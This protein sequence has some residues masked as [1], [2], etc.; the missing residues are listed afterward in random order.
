M[1][2][3][4]LDT[5]TQQRYL[6]WLLATKMTAPDPGTET[7]SGDMSYLELVPLGGLPRAARRSPV[8]LVTSAESD[9]VLLTPVE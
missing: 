4:D 8:Y 9:F 1:P 7:K 6:G 3:W 5:D 2:W